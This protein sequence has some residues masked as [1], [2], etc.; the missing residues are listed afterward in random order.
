MISAS[1]PGKLVILLSVCWCAKHMNVL[2]HLLL[3]LLLVSIL[4]IL[5]G[6]GRGDGVGVVE[7]GGVHISVGAVAGIIAVGVVHGAV[8]V[9]E[10]VVDRLNAGEVG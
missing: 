7:H 1:Y 10:G 6:L 8:A 4:R 9:L 3:V 5:L 2:G